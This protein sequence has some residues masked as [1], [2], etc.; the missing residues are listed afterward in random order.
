[1]TLRA[2]AAAGLVEER[3]GGAVAEAS[4][5]FASDIAPWISLGF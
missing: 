2:L 4:R 1:V 3:R 5:A